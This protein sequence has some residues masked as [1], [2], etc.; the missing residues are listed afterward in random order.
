VQ[1]KHLCALFSSQFNGRLK[2]FHPRYRMFDSCLKILYII[3]YHDDA[4]VPISHLNFCTFFC[5]FHS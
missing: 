5:P 4:W 3:F 2:L 1:F